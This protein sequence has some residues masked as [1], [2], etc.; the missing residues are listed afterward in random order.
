MGR[1]PAVESDCPGAIDGLTPWLARST[2]VQVAWPELTRSF[3][4]PGQAFGLL[5]VGWTLT[6]EMTFSL[7]LPLMYFVARGWGWPVLLAGAVGILVVGRGIELYAID[8][9]LGLITFLE[10]ERLQALVERSSAA[11]RALLVGVAVLAFS[12]PLLLGWTDEQMRVLVGGSAPRDIAVTGVGCF[13]IVVAALYVPAVN[14]LLVRP[15]VVWLGKVSF[16]V[17]LIHRTLIT[18]LAPRVVTAPG[19]WLDG[20]LLLACVALG[21]LVLS[22]VAYRWVELPAIRIGNWICE[23]LS[24]AAG[25]GSVRSQLVRPASQAGGTGESR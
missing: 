4:F 20:L 22:A 6:V 7:L 14:R 24:R 25:T 18:I 23:L 19:G 21:S 5:P 2:L 16:S 15:W 13:G 12:T 9:T 10:R 17:Y 1:E 11:V 8:F 3:V